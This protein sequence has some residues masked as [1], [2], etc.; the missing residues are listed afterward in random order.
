[1]GGDTTRPQTFCYTSFPNKYYAPIV[2]ATHAICP[3]RRRCA[4][5]I[6]VRCGT[7]D[8]THTHTR[9]S[10]MYLVNIHGKT[11]NQFTHLTE[12]FPYDSLGRVTHTACARIRRLPVTIFM[13]VALSGWR[14]IYESAVAC[15]H[16]VCGVYMHMGTHSNACDAHVFHMGARTHACRQAGTTL[17]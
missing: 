3:P 10:R 17:V 15:I 12:S 14:N 9:S 5:Y 1:M 4:Q 16:C 11:T 7:L 13:V 6:C 2:C 8:S